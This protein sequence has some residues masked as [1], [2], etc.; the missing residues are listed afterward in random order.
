M[1]GF[2]STVF[3]VLLPFVLVFHIVLP[4]L[5]S[6]VILCMMSKLPTT[7]SL[8]DLKRLVVVVVEGADRHA[9]CRFHCSF[10]LFMVLSVD[11]TNSSIFVLVGVISYTHLFSRARHERSWRR[12][13]N[14]AI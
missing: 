1:N 3:L 14:R 7:R 11:T 6:I 12:N 10:D 2:L 13:V 4:H 8:E 9:P 5:P